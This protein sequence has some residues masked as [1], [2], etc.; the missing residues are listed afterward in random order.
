MKKG[1]QMKDRRNKKII[2]SS[3]LITVIY[4]GLLFI[5]YD[6]SYSEEDAWFSA[7]FSGKYNGVADA[8]V[9]WMRYILGYIISCFYKI[10]GLLNWYAIFMWTIIIVSF[11]LMVKRI[12]KINTDRSLALLENAVFITVYTANFLNGFIKFNFSFVAASV[13]IV[14]VFYVTTMQTIDNA[15]I[16]SNMICI[17][18]SLILCSWIRYEVG[19]I[20]LVICAEIT[21]FLFV[22]YRKKYMQY[23]VIMWMLIGVFYVVTNGVEKIAYSN[24]EEAARLEHYD[25]RR[26]IHDYYGYPEYGEAKAIYDKYGINEAESK[27]FENGFYTLEDKDTMYHLVR[28]LS[29][30]VKNKNKI[31][32][33]GAFKEKVLNTIISLFEYW[34]KSEYAFNNL[35]ILTLSILLIILYELKSEW[36]EALYL[37]FILLT[38][39]AMWF[40]LIWRGRINEHAI[41]PVQSIFFVYVFGML[42]NY[43]KEY[44]GKYTKHQMIV[45]N[46]VLCFVMIYIVG[47]HGV[48]NE[49]FSKQRSSEAAFAEKVLEYANQS[50]DE[51]YYT[52]TYNTSRMIRIWDT[53][54]N[55]QMLYDVHDLKNP[56]IKNLKKENYYYMVAE[57][58]NYMVDWIEQALG[59]VKGEIVNT[60]KEGSYCVEVYKFE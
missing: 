45:S 44:G 57:N 20:A 24:T 30:F 7:S 21:F 9:I 41:I 25:D 37:L 52:S 33:I 6:F 2:V 18:G 31:S 34:T 42:L 43:I 1:K 58:E 50:R 35:V 23:F 26:V 10:N 40:M 8:H 14:A 56:P 29:E 17:V 27:L 59:G 32:S 4:F 38:N 54:N 47:Y 13:A 15:F 53:I 5:L 39:G 3:V 12:F 22:K 51:I 28:D 55:S 11:Y 49:N 46:C 16:K 48:V 60:I 36:M 19:W